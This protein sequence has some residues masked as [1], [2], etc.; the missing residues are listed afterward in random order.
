MKAVIY[1]L[2]IA[3]LGFAAWQRKQIVDLQKAEQQL[4]SPAAA[5]SP[6]PERAPEK[7]IAPAPDQSFGQG[8]S[9]DDFARFTSQVMGRKRDFE[10]D[11]FNKFARVSS[12]N[13]AAF[14]DLSEAL[15]RLSPDQLLSVLKQWSGGKPVE[16]SASDGPGNF[17]MLVERVN[18][19]ALV[20]LIYRLQEEKDPL[21]SK[22][23]PQM[24]LRY[25]FRQ[26]SNELLQW[27]RAAGTPGGFDNVCA[28]WADAA[29]II[30]EPSLE[31]VRRFLA[32]GSSYEAMDATAALAGQLPSDESRLQYFQNLHTVTKGKVAKT[33]RYLGDLPR[34]TSFGK[35]AHLVDSLPPL[36]PTD[37]GK[38]SRTFFYGEP[39]GSLRYELA[40]E[41]RDGT[42]EQRW[43]WLL[44]RPSDA[45]SEKLLIRLVR[46]WR[47]YDF[48]DTAAWAKSLPPGPN[49]EIVHREIARFLKAH[50][51]E[52]LAAE[53]K[54]P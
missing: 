23:Y 15:S 34:T 1:S 31:N 11:R 21:L 27:A 12:G 18:P 48:A 17:L 13:W 24:A 16:R 32:H 49:R 29:E 30:R 35:L 37:P 44:Q 10:E 36:E 8:L 39:L 26:D 45:P 6:A 7:L 46:E 50:G 4:S 47:D 20:K 43:Q 3:S 9:E 33:D 53:W 14:P 28:I 25:W 41:S 52:N 2:V 19:S 40:A 54:A 5:L 38:E 22:P 42:A 51:K